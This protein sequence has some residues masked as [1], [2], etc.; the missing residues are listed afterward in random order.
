MLIYISQDVD[1]FYIFLFTEVHIN[2][3]CLT[4][5]SAQALEQFFGNSP[6]PPKASMD[7]TTNTG[8]S[9]RAEPRGNEDGQHRGNNENP[10]QGREQRNP[11]GADLIERIL[12]PVS[13]PIQNSEEYRH[14]S[15]IAFLQFKVLEE[16]L[17]LRTELGLFRGVHEAQAEHAGPPPRIND[18]QSG[19]RRSRSRSPR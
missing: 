15:I 13:S 7:S 11:S 16:L 14:L 4:G 8:G 1:I 17:N 9:G 12:G 3:Y 19:R 18:D 6:K 5:E 2:K 10:Q